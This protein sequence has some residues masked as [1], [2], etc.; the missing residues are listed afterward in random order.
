[1]KKLTIFSICLF[2][3]LANLPVN[4]TAVDPSQGYS[5]YDFNYN[6]G[7]SK[8]YYVGYVYAPTGM[9]T[10]GQTLSS[11]PEEMGGYSLG[12]GYYSITKETQGYDSSYDKKEYI[13]SY[14]NFS[15]GSW[16]DVNND[17]SL[18]ASHI[19]VSDRTKVDEWGYSIYKSGTGFFNPFTPDS[20]VPLPPTLLLL[21]SGLLGLLGIGW[22]VRKS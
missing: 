9:L 22:R 13:T 16:L 19:Y 4:A 11:E 18:T 2:L 20:V 7:G 17:A 6:Y 1:M 14:Y 5:R 15:V 3:C 12:G 8:D 10:V 21:G